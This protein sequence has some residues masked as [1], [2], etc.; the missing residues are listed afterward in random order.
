L[1]LQEQNKDN[2]EFSQNKILEQL[3]LILVSAGNI[4]LDI[5]SSDKFD[6]E[7]VQKTRFNSKFPAIADAVK[8]KFVNKLNLR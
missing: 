3:L 7:I 1:I 5:K 6:N 4:G 2:V 8:K